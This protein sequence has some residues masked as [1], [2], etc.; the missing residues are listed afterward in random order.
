MEKCSQDPVPF[1][2]GISVAVLIIGVQSVHK[3][4]Q[5]VFAIVIACLATPEEWV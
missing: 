2:A 4:N 1:L 3:L 5:L